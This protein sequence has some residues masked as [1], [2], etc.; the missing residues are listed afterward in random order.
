LILGNKDL[1]N[2]VVN[3]RN[4]NASDKAGRTLLHRAAEAADREAVSVL[5]KK[6]SLVNAGDSKRETPLDRAFSSPDSLPHIR[7]AELLILSGAKSSNANLAYIVPAIR[8]SNY[9]IRFEGG[10]SPLH[11]AAQEGHLGVVN[12]LIEKK[13]KIDA[14][15]ASGAPPLHEAFRAGEV[16]AAKLLIQAGADVN[17]RDANGNAAMHL[18]MPLNARQAGLDLLLANKADPNIKDNHGDAP[19]HIAVA[20]NL[21]LE[22][23]RKLIANG[24]DTNIRNTEGK[25]PL[26]TAV[27]RDRIE[28][29]SLLISRGADIFATDQQGNTAFDLALYKGGDTMKATITQTTVAATDK[30]GNTQLH[31]AVMSRSAVDTIAF[32]LDKKA[33]V[34]ARNMSGDTPLHLAV[35]TNQRET[36]E[37]LIAR[38]GDIFAVNS[39][40]RIRSI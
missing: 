22:I 31:V 6:G 15:N 35:Q 2:S 29:I 12:Y 28:Y 17:A 37:L 39:P 38:K 13:A 4:V 5:L 18:V 14:K 7:T 26:H 23:V 20:T 32:I 25:T 36:G 30:Q 9:D 16:E 1:L 3:E 40:A 33:A 21:G 10:L 19:L 11:F 27:E 24:A 34:N 8:Q